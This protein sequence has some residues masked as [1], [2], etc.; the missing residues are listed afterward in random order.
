MDPWTGAEV[1]AYRLGMLIGRGPVGAVYRALDQDTGQRVALKVLEE[2]RAGGPTAVRSVVAAARTAAGLQHQ[3]VVPV[4]EAGLDEDVGFVAMAHVENGD[5]RALMRWNGPLDPARALTLVEQAASGLDA[6]HRAGLLHGNVK[7]SNLLVD[8]RAGVEHILV[9]DFGR[10]PGQGT[11]PQA[12]DVRYLA[13]E[14]VEGVAG[15]SA[16]VY[17]LGCVLHETLTG[18]PAFPQETAEEV[19]EA[20]RTAPRP[21][22][23]ATE[24]GLPASID[25]V[26]A[27]ATAVDPQSRFGSCGDLVAAARA[28]LALVATP[29][30]GSVPAGPGIAPPAGPPSSGPPPSEPPS[31]EPTW[32]GDA[33]PIWGPGDRTPRRIATARD[34]HDPYRPYERRRTVPWIVAGVSILGMIVLLGSIWAG[35]SSGGGPDLGPGIRP[36]PATHTSP[37]PSPTPSSSRSPSPSASPSPLPSPQVEGVTVLVLNGTQTAGLATDAASLLE[38][39]GFTTAPPG[40]V[41]QTELTTIYYRPE[42][43]VDARYI[44]GRFFPVARI[45]PGTNAEP[46]DVHIVVILGDDYVQAPPG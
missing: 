44:G 14:A 13:P 22:P 29:A 26:L 10:A 30:R 37:R 45:L 25:P 4:M 17:A 1:G 9:S 23:S 12:D 3:H 43:E 36:L 27:Q 46:S 19:L 5:L 20:H 21:R 39:A 24:S 18:R 41:S 33:P 32:P 42:Y 38:S 6:A 31:S 35:G 28:A 2:D 34:D 16:D 40:N 11:P 8:R 15:P 7:P